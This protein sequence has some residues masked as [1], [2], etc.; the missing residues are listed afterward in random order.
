MKEIRRSHGGRVA[1]AEFDFDVLDAPGMLPSKQLEM[2]VQ[3]AQRGDPISTRVLG[4]AGYQLGMA[5]ANV[6]QILNPQG[7]VIGGALTKANR[8]MDQFTDAV[9][10]LTKWLPLWPVPIAPSRWQESATLV[11]AIALGVRADD[12]RFAE[13]LWTLIE[14]SLRD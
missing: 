2:V 11:G 12:A 3:W 13:R 1:P 10:D 8:F 14:P 9:H 7:I 5:V 4:D 6:C